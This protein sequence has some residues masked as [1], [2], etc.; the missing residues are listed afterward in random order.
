MASKRAAGPR[1]PIKRDRC[2][3][4]PAGDVE[5]TRYHD[6]EWG[7]PVHADRHLFEMLTLEG[8]QAGLSW[9]TILRKRAAY[10]K[11]FAG[12][13][14]A[15]VARFDARRRAALLQDPGIVRNRL[16]I[17]STVSN[18]QAFL[19]LQKELGSFDRYLWNWVGGHPVRNGWR[20]R[21]QVP[22]SSDLSDRISRDL[23]KRGFR[24]VGST[25]IYAYL[26]AVGVLNDHTAGCYLYQARPAAGRVA[27][28]AS[29][30]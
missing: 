11:A 1:L 10:R 8:A 29:R 5:Y 17:D 21:S 19:A 23:K 7:R 13:D 16:K 24:F 22:A 20:I 26:Q 9:S 28:K 3:W 30:S 12:F 2:G 25:I 6:E 4:V 15:K 14:P 27:R 18:A